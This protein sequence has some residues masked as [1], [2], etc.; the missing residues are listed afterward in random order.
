MTAKNDPK[1]ERKRR[2]GGI[3]PLP[4]H[5]RSIDDERSCVGSSRRRMSGDKRSRQQWE[6]NIPSGDVRRVSQSSLDVYLNHRPAQ[7][8]RSIRWARA[9]YQAPRQYGH[10][11]GKLSRLSLRRRW[12][13]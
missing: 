9:H 5:R 13:D 6:G 3:C 12:D 11:R 1:R 10:L 2:R 4:S 7:M 8:P